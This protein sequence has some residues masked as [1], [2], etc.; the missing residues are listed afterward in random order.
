MVV[1]LESALL[2]R[3]RVLIE[4]FIRSLGLLSARRTRKY[5]YVLGKILR[6]LPAPCDQVSQDDL[7]GYVQGINSSEFQPWTKYEYRLVVKK[8]FGWLKNKE[9]VSWVKLGNVKATVGPEDILSDAELNRLRHVCENLRDKA[10]VETLYE[11]ACRPQEFLG[12]R[13][14]DVSF[15]EFGAIVYV[16]QGKTGP[17]RIRVVNASPLLANWTE[18]HPLKSKEAPLWVGL[19]PN[20]KCEALH[21]TG[22]KRLVERLA[23]NSNLEK[24]VFAYI[25]RHTRLSTLARF[26]TEAQLCE[27]AGWEQGSDMPRMYIHFSGRDVDEALLKAYGLVK[28]EDTLI[29]KAP[30]KCVRCSTLC[31]SSAETCSKCGMALTLEAALKKDEEMKKMQEQIDR[32]NRKFESLVNSIEKTGLEIKRNID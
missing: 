21:W 3:N 7:R 12:L 8:F 24:N 5:R 19:S 28:Q 14:C 20:K 11:S 25:F 13:K 17:R 16:R 31:E 4:D 29:A 1:R 23:K 26:M 27:F 32:M 9:F 10:L 15:D 22:L 30:R 6:E 18:N 2:D